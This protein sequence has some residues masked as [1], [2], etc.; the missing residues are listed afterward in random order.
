MR[1]APVAA[2]I[3][4]LSVS[5]VP[6]ASASPDE[7]AA[8]L[9]GRALDGAGN[10]QSAPRLGPRQR[11]LPA[12][13]ARRLRGWGQDDGRRS[14]RPLRQQPRLQRRR[15]ERLLRERRDAVG[16]SCGASSWTTRSGCAR[17]PAAKT[18]RSPLIAR[19]P[20]EA[21]RQRLRGDRLLPLTRRARHRRRR[22]P[23]RADQHGLELHRRARPSTATTRRGCRGCATARGSSSTPPAICRAA[24]ATR[25]PPRWL[26][27]VASPGNPRRR[28]SRATSAPTRTSR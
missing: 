10:N 21:L 8:A 26:S 7:I 25:P 18:R 3:A 9:A 5:V 6:A 27:R 20:L 1:A 22:R 2:I 12:P 11:H 15:P 24:G 13:R 17:R 28:W 23:A 16:G 4:V 19:D 14:A